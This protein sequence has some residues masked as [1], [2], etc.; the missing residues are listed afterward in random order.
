MYVN[1]KYRSP[2]PNL[3]DE[4]FI[5]FL[6]NLFLHEN[7]EN[8]WNTFYSFLFDL[9]LSL[10]VRTVSANVKESVV[11]LLMCYRRIGE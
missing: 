8:S 4:N 10:N 5:Y 7:D 2:I 3:G 11:Y 1:V 6:K 9:P